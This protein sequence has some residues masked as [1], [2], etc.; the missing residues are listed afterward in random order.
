MINIWC[1]KK[2]EKLKTENIGRNNTM[3]IYGWR[4]QIINSKSGLVVDIFVQIY[5]IGWLIWWRHCCYCWRHRS[6]GIYKIKTKTNKTI[7]TKKKEPK[8]MNHFVT[9]QSMNHWKITEL[10]LLFTW[11]IVLWI[12]RM[13]I[14]LIG[15]WWLIWWH[16]RAHCFWILET[17]YS[18]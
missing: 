8:Y 4:N 1:K 12:R 9:W 7:K 5:R 11:L 16:W 10:R 15:L 18:S 14:G 2:S 17:I 3:L 6:V 13:L